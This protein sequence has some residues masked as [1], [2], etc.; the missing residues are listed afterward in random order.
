MVTQYGHDEKFASLTTDELQVGAVVFTECLQ[1]KP[2]ESV[3]IVTDEKLLKPE[4]AIFFES[5][6]TYANNVL[7]I[8][9][10]VANEHA[11]EPPSE[12]AHLMENMDIALL[13]TTYS[14]SHTTA[15]LDAC[16]NGTRIIS[17]PTITKE[18]ILRTIPIDYSEVS[19][20]SKKV[21]AAQTAGSKAHITSPNGT[22]LMINLTGRDA[23]ADTGFFTNPGDFGN[24]PAGES[25]IAPVEGTSE[26]IIVFDGC[27]ADIVLDD[28]ITVKVK[29][30][31]AVDITGGEA[32]RLLNER[33]ARAGERAYNIAEF[34]IGTNNHTKLGNNLLEVEKV[35]GTCHIALGNNATFG[36][37]VDVPFHSDGVILKPKI[38]IDRKV[39]LENGEF[40]L[41]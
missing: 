3:L 9:I 4:A 25:F 40:K 24:L 21:A 26:G 27:F 16:R 23:I 1:L 32:A 19:A 14:L 34:G 20:L 17:M 13:I 30:G 18:M 5:A 39:I 6:K 38:E 31:H 29:N 12:A 11:E 35:Y 37:E 28:P 10:P 7:M 15:R 41:Q 8:E 22:D 33:L 2:H 36:G